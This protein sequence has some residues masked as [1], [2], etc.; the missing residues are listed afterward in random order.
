VQTLKPRHGGLSTG[1]KTPERKQRSLRGDASWLHGVA[2]SET[3]WHHGETR[4]IE[5]I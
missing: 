1:P 4:V 5:K 2:Q 3:A